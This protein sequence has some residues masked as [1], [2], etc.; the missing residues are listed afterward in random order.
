MQK[1]RVYNKKVVIL[2]QEITLWGFFCLLKTAQFL[3]SDKVPW[4]IISLPLTYNLYI[5]TYIHTYIHRYK[6]TKDSVCV[7]LF[8][9]T[10]NIY[11]EDILTI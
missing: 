3:S 1:G 6:K 7:E 5:Y 4:A 10:F 11:C 9:F 8:F 2:W